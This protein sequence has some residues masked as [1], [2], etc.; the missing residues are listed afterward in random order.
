MRTQTSIRNAIAALTA[1]LLLA[2]AVSSA[3]ARSLSVSNQ[4]IRVTWAR[5]EFAEALVTIRCQVTL[6]GSFHTQTIAKIVGSLV[7]YVTRAIM[8]QSAC[9]NGRG[10]VFNGTEAYNGGTAP[11][12]LPWH[13]TY[14]SFQGSLPNITALQALVTGFRTGIEAS[15]CVAQYGAA[16]DNITA[17]ANR[18]ASG[19]LTSLSPVAGRNGLTKIREDNDPFNIC[20]GSASMVGTSTSLSVLSSTTR[21]TITLI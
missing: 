8:N 13:L 3:S 6:E 16:T 7:G 18:E 10:A 19:G 15:G 14:E 12:T 9:T 11:N 1:T 4:S 5:L 21:L 20:P 2:C 17:S